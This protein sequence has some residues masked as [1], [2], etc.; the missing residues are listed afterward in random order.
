MRYTAIR[1]VQ[2]LVAKALPTK[3]ASGAV[4]SFVVLKNTITRRIYFID[5][6]DKSKSYRKRSID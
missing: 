4:E 5:M 3:T 2:K 1:D 6:T